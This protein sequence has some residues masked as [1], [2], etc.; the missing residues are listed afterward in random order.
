[1]EPDRRAEPPGSIS[2]LVDPDP[3]SVILIALGAAGS[4]ASLLS[5]AGQ[6]RAPARAERELNQFALR[7][8]VLGMET[9]LNE[10][11]GYVHS[12]EILAMSSGASRT[13]DLAVP[14]TRVGF[15]QI[16]V[17]FTRQG[18]ERWRE[19]EA[20]IIAGAIGIG[21][22]LNDL[23]RIL[24]STE[25]RLPRDAIARL[26]DSISG[27]NQIVFSMR[28]MSFGQL[29]AEC[30]ARQSDMIDALRLLREGIPRWTQ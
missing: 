5:Y 29:F 14:E 13:A 4:V 7:D 18:Y 16:E 21:R 26:Q 6:R 12:A 1:M 30:E 3:F 20:G 9:S 25:T 23:L 27:M 19:V 17:R 8:A 28:D 10:L 11:R 2:G 15:G 22:H 24:S